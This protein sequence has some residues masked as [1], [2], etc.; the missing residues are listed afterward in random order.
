MKEETKSNDN[1][2]DFLNLIKT[3]WERRFFIFTLTSIF[4]LVAVIYSLQLPNIYNSTAILAPTKPEESL[5]SPLSSSPFVD[6]PG[7]NFAK[8]TA[9]KSEEA[10][11]RIKSFEFFSNYLLPNIK[12]EDIVAVKKWNA[13]KN[14]TEYNS[15][16]FESSYKAPSN[17][18]AFKLFRQSLLIKVDNRTSFVTLSI[19]HQSPVTAKNWLEIIIE[20]INESMRLEDISTAE[21]YVNFLN[22]SQRTTNIQSL[23]DA[24]SNL[25]EGQMQTLMLASSK[26]DY[27][28]KTID[29]PIIP[30]SKSG[31]S[32]FFIFIVL[33]MLGGFLSLLIV[34]YQKYRNDQ[35]LTKI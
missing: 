1:E 27:V 29:S 14:I 26:K 35:K 8:G 31:P 15:N 4:S 12:L 30:E 16:F 19:S 32:R 10:V 18:V 5:S 7:I 2:L 9:S 28:F 13:K 21:G 6:L 34:F 3:A 25:L 23:K 22:L 17:Q 20:N 11:E 33:T 24:I